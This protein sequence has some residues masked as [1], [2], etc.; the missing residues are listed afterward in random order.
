M[1]VIIDR[2][3]NDR[4]KSAVNRERF[5]RRYKAHVQRAVADMVAE[6][7]VR[8]MEHG[9][10]VK[11]PAKD[12]AEP[13]FRHGSGGDREY[14]HT[15]NREFMP[16]DRIERP[17]S[18]G[19]GGGAG[20]GEGD[21]EDGFVFTLSR[22]EFMQI[23]FDDLELPRMERT[24]FGEL[25]SPRL[26]RAGYTQQGAPANL[27]VVRSLRNALGRR[28]ALSGEARRELSLREAELAALE[29][30]SGPEAGGSRDG[31]AGR[32]ALESEIAELRRR[33]ARV[34]FL[35]EI[36]LRFR[37][38]TAVPQ[39]I[40][41]AVMFCL[42]DV[43]A[44]MEEHHKDLAKRF[45]ALLHMFLVRK[46]E[47]VEVVFIRHTDDA[48]EVDEERF[49]HDPKSGGTVVYSA[50]ELMRSIIADRYPVTAWN[51]YGAQASDGDAFG[52][53]P[54]RSRGLLEREL[55]PSVRHYAYVEV[56]DGASARTS[57]L[58]AAYRRIEAEQFAMREVHERRDIHPV[59]RGLFERE[60][61]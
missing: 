41:Q 40:S 34:P 35:D 32:A 10:D 59:F 51:I 9:G 3:L 23:F 7:S 30:A 8:D 13:G 54:E 20:G 55:L 33:V 29:G 16:G 25:R 53:D 12:I 27:S 42:M 47:R 22:E 43:S 31:A 46:Y 26:Q 2:R 28:V 38:R 37:H 14:V 4:N 39:P 15:G 44:S 11:I 48:E 49:F 57:T 17:R 21:A 50:L 19:G 36:D 60:S 52:A 5:M 61:H 6:R 24:A 1:S 56:G 58:A 45:F 18:G